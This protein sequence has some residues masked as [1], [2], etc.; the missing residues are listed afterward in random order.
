MSTF[1]S[2]DPV[3][4]HLD[5]VDHK[6]AGKH[7]IMLTD[8]QRNFLLQNTGKLSVQ[9]RELLDTA[10]RGKFEAT[11]RDLRAERVTVTTL[12]AMRAAMRSIPHPYPA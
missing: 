6:I 1:S 2:C 8:L 10:A 3:R 7:A 5:R 4:E 11:T 9:E 12:L